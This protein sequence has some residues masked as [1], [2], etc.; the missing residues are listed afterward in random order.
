MSWHQTSREVAQAWLERRMCDEQSHGLSMWAVEDREL[1]HI[2]GLCGFFPR[3]ERELEL[4]YVIAAPLVEKR[5]A[6][7]GGCGL[8]DH[9]A[10]EYSIVA[11]CGKSRLAVR[12]Q[13]SRRVG[14]LEGKVAITETSIPQGQG[15]KREG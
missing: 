12:G 6:Q 7:R 11:S 4:G 8:C 2:L 14:V 13:H 10:M 5:S 3:G 15:S 1:H 9:Q